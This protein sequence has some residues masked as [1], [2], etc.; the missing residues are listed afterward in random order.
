[1][2]RLYPPVIAAALVFAACGPGSAASVSPSASAPGSPLSLQSAG[3]SSLPSSGTHGADPSGSFDAIPPADPI[4]GKIAFNIGDGALWVMDGNGGG[5]RRITN[6]PGNDF[7]PKWTADGTSIVFRTSRGAYAPDVDGTGTEGIFVVDATTGQERQLY[8]PNA[9]T[10]GGLFADPGPNDLVALSTIDTD[11]KEAIV[12]LDLEGRRM[13]TIKVKGGEC[14]RWS[15]DGSRIAY[16]HLT[17]GIFA[18]W[19]MNA[20]GT[21][22]R[23]LSSTPGRAYPGPWSPDGRRLL[24]NGDAPNGSLEVFV[25]DA[26]GGSARPLTSMPG[27]QAP[28][29]WLPDGRILFESWPQDAEKPEWF[30]ISSDGSGLARVVPFERAGVMGGVSWHP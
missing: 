30:V 12:I 18:V 13:R 9:K 8:P 17:G 20:D 29:A 25:M 19:A 14:S 24:F 3:S 10:V 23:Q 22:R 1:M 4:P 28:D 2:K 26:D 11:G 5:Q 7:D 27:A 15:P 16:C 21:H 6:P